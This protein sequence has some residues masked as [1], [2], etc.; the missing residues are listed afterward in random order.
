[1]DHD[2]NIHLPGLV[3][4]SHQNLLGT[5]SFQDNFYSAFDNVDSRFGSRPDLGPGLLL[6]TCSTG[7]A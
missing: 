5:L 1:M 2:R 6:A 7:A 4:D 3:R